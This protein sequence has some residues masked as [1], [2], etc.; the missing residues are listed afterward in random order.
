[1]SD[2]AKTKTFDGKHKRQQVRLMYNLDKKSVRIVCKL[3]E[4]GSEYIRKLITDRHLGLV[5][6]VIY[7]ARYDSKVVALMRGPGLDNFLRLSTKPK[8]SDV[9]IKNRKSFSEMAT[10]SETGS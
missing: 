10:D 7:S 8:N 1:M 3:P 9:A 2:S 4:T 6:A 5:D